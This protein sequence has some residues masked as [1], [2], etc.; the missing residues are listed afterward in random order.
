MDREY[1]K[2]NGDQP[3]ASCY[4]A[5]LSKICLTRKIC[6]GSMNPRLLS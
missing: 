1:G 2:S 3:G 6:K 5:R 4:I